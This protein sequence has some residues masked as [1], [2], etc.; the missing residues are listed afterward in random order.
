MGW[1]DFFG[2]G[3]GS[4]STSDLPTLFPLGISENDF[5]TIDVMN[6]Y[7]KILTDV[8]ERSDGL[9]EDQK[10]CLW[11]NCLQ[12][13]SYYGLISLLARAMT[14][15]AEL[16]LVFDVATNVLRKA[17]SDE[18]TKI[19]ADYE[20]Q[21]QSTIGVFVSFKTYSR[22]DMVRL[23]SALEHCTVAGLNKSMNLSKAV[24]IKIS[25]LRGGVSLGDSAEATTQGKAMAQGLSNGKD[26][27]MDALDTVETAKPDLT[28]VKAAMEFLNEKRSFYLGLPASYITGELN[29]G[30]GDSGQADAKAIERGLKSY[31]FSIIKPV[32]K[33]LFEVDLDFD[34]DDFAQITTA[35]EVMKVF[36]LTSEELMTTENK[37][38]IINRLFGFPDEELGG[39]P[40]PPPTIVVPPRAPVPPPK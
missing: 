35:T 12:S 23:Y 22:T 25:M 16:F 4:S 15:K 20:K 29:S 13:N 19:R 18:Q 3:S 17:T 10:L 9:T 40:A 33:A 2:F 39:P 38:K 7:T 36:E 5:I 14:D 28:S 11:D 37:V 27:L 34:S 6:T 24:Q 21:A 8:I 26:I 30:L 31:F 32:C 1:S